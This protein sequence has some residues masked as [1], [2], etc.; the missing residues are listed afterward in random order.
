LEFGT[1]KMD[2]RPFFRPAISE[3]RRQGVDDFLKSNTRLT[4]ERIEDLD[5]LVTAVA[6]AMERRVKEII[7]EKSIIDTGTLRA[8]IAAVPGGEVGDLATE[9]DLPDTGS[10]PPFPTDFGPEIRKDIEIQT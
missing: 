2:P 6:L 4:A 9:D 1:K 5:S 3:L 7:T 8:S 10:G